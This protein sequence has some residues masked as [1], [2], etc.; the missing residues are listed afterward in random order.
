MADR[1]SMKQLDNLAARLSQTLDLPAEP[2][3]NGEAQ[4][5]CIT[6]SSYNGG[7][8][9]VQMMEHGGTKTL[10]DN[11]TARET[12]AWLQGALTACRLAGA[13]GPLSERWTGSNVLGTR[14]AVTVRFIGP[15]NY[16]PS[17]WQAKHPDRGTVYGPFT[18][19]PIAAAE[20]WATK[21]GLR[22]T[23][24]KRIIQLTPDLYA[25][26]F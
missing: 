5:G 3:L 1:T 6:L 23:K 18:D 19:G 11:S 13:D 22:D 17:R 9:V 15:T 2:Y 26:E 20:R 7:H 21:V 8:S 10:S 16:R 25:I 14:V 4:K 12:V 24:A